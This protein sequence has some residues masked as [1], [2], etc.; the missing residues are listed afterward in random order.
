L[1]SKLFTHEIYYFAENAECDFVVF[2]QKKIKALYQVCWQLDQEN[3]HREMAGLKEAMGFFNLDW[4]F[5]ITTNQTDSFVFDN[6]T[7]KMLPF[8]QWAKILDSEQ[9]LGNAF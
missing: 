3:I 8:Y 7:I 6:M 1:K 5:I 4:G 2:Q 9:G